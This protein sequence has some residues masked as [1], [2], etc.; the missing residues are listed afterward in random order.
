MSLMFSLQMVNVRQSLGIVLVSGCADLLEVDPWR[1]MG[2][3]S[4]EDNSPHREPTTAIPPYEFT[5][6]Y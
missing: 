6:A 4:I 2:M 5:V 1:T 3:A